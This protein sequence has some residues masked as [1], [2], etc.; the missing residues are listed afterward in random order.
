MHY[1]KLLGKTLRDVPQSIRTPSYALLH[2]GGFVR[3]MAQ[4]LYSFLPMGMKVLQNIQRIIAEEMQALGGQEIYVPVVTPSDIWRRSGRLDW[5]GELIPFRDRHGREL[6]LSPTHEEAFVE[7][8]RVALSSYREMPLFLY[9]FQIKFRDEERTKDGLV[10]T[11]EIYMHDAYSFHRSYQDLNNFF[12]K[13]FTAYKKVFDRCGIETFAGEAGVGYIGG[14]KSYEFL[15][16]TD[17]ADHA[18]IL[19]DKCQY[20]AS[21][22]VAVG[23]KKFL[24]EQ[25]RALEKVH[26]PGCATIDELAEFLEVPKERTAK[27]LVYDT[28]QGLVMA[29]VRGD[30]ELGLEKLSGYLKYP[31]YRPASDEELAAVGL[32]PGYLSPVGGDQKIRVVVDDA[33]AKSNNL[34]FGANQADHHLI[35]G[36]FG[37][38]FD[39]PDVTD[40]A[41][42]RDEK[43]CLQCGGRLREIQALEVG[44]IFKLGDYYT[45]MMNLTYQDERGGSTYPHMGCYGVGLGRLMDA[46]VR[47]NHDDRGILWPASLAPFQ[48]YLM[49][50]GKSLGVKKVVEELHRELGERALY[51]DRSDSPGVKFMD[52]DLIGIPLRIVVA[53]K[54]LGD[55][56]V[57]LKERRSGAIHLVALDQLNRAVDDLVARGAGETRAMSG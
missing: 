36:N 32:V 24:R 6:V 8:V 9:Q 15:M 29:V 30:Y 37:R 46:V 43:I 27:S 44:H 54:H 25:E 57:E 55:G 47:S 10:R 56:K 12:P 42:T 19:C 16:P 17:A 38:D 51:D 3:Q 41:L 14:E 2:R 40:I 50:V 28:P 4:G 13:T 33:V 35:N 22:E 53:A 5:I 18:I 1:T 31:A 11:K 52:A 23:G 45:R 34:V 39:T 20:C 21:K 26:T 49:S 48:V 7:L